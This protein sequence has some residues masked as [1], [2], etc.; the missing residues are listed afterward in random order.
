M[1]KKIKDLP[2]F[3]TPGADN[4]EPKEDLTRPTPQRTINYQTNRTDFS[5][6]ITGAIGPGVYRVEKDGRKELG[7]MSKSLKF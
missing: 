4:Y 1:G 6:S 7:K 3:I 5:K 2:Q